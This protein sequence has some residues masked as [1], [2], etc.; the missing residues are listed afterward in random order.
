MNKVF[1]MGRLVKNP[2]TKYTQNQN[3]V[4]NFTLAVDRAYKSDGQTNTDF[5][6]IQAWGKTSEFVSKY[7]IKGLR[8]LVE[9]RIQNRS[10]ED[11]SGTK[12][13][14]TDIIA[15]QVFFADGKKELVQNQNNSD[16][17]L[18]NE[19]DELPF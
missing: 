6:N 17:E 18:P 5:F 13:Y 11:D 19:G 16:Y 15:L 12:K 3:Q 8:V 10:W 2:E 4:T 14:A 9:G 7:F 1:L